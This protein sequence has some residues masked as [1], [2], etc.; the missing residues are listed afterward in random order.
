M[1]ILEE[2]IKQPLELK[3]Y[4]NGEWVESKS[5][6]VSEVVNPATRKVIA[7]Y[8][9][10]TA[11]EVNAA[12]QAAADAFPEWRRTTPL[13]RVRCL[14][15][16]RDLMEENFE[17]LSR[18]Q[19]QEHG[20]TIDESR[21][22]TRRGIEMVE[23]ATGIPSLMM[24]YNLEDI[25]AGIDEYVIYQPLG[26]FG[27]IAPFNFPFMVPLWFSPFALATGNTFVVKPSPRAP[28]SQTRLA[29]L[30]EEAGFPP[31]VYNLVHGGAEAAR[32]MIDHPDI[33]GI[34][35]VGTT[36]VG[37]EVYARCGQTGK[38]A[39]VQASAKNFLV[40]MPDAAEGTIPALL[41]S[42]F[43]NTGQRC[44]SGANVV[45]VGR[46]GASYKKF[47]DEF[48]EATSRIKVGYG[49]DE[50]V[51]MGPMQAVDGKE[52]TIGYVEKGIADGARL[53]L[54]GRQLKITGD[55]PD[56]CF[57]G[58]TVFEGVTPDMAIGRE[59]I[60]GP[61]ATVMR[62]ASLDEA[63]TAINA[64]H[65]G[66]AACIFTASGRAAREFQYRVTCGNIGINIGIAAPM[67]F[68]PFSGMKDSF[69]GVLH[70]QGR[71]AIRFF[72]E[73]KVAIQRWF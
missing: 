43:G 72:T 7:G 73:S 69:F 14:F 41:T 57:L 18:I 4:I 9:T 23:V 33:K 48:V 28:I 51:Q 5:G 54:D 59:E 45:I 40:I 34:T 49:L 71:D 55:Y 56:D 10:S 60:F 35:F 53:L 67:A 61:V 1:A 24:G 8:P 2:P 17:S 19:T 39:I 31:G 27:H 66:N 32:I 68:F 52:R 6:Q 36:H 47:L 63:I 22:E 20:K 29:E 38:R 65:Y 13:A 26:V 3:N 11:D 37:K 15:R 44:L 62:T 42:L 64:S 50:S 70:G 21:G 46:G 25:A 58:P 30:I 12:I 16:L